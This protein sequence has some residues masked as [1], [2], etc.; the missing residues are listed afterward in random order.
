MLPCGSR[1]A[2]REVLG[3]RSVRTDIGEQKFHIGLRARARPAHSAEL[4]RDVVHLNS[5]RGSDVGSGWS[6]CP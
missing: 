4:H 6:S 2:K 3:A 1:I 5:G